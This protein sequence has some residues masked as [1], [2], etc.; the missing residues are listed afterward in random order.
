LAGPSTVTIAGASEHLEN[1]DVQVLEITAAKA[2]DT[3]LPECLS[4][5]G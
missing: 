2:S 4:F 5:Q 1:Y 3:V